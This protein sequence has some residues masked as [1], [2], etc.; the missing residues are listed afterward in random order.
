MFE[1]SGPGG[2][3]ALPVFWGRPPLAS[4]GHPGPELQNQS[5]TKVLRKRSRGQSRRGPS[6]GVIAVRR[7]GAELAPCVT[8]KWSPV[9]RCCRCSRAW[10]KEQESKKNDKSKC[11]VCFVSTDGQCEC[12]PSA[13]GRPPVGEAAA[14]GLRVSMYTE[15]EA[16]HRSFP[17]T[18]TATPRGFQ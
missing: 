11:T 18:C 9:V 1:H 6:W 17:P 15:H 5:L 3:P 12:T 13:L 16:C 7:R 14:P 8:V 4:G 2:P 10:G